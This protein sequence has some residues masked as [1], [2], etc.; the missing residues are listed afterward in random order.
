MAPILLFVAGVLAGL[1]AGFVLSRRVFR[2]RRDDGEAERKGP[3]E[4]RL[5]AGQGLEPFANDLQAQQ[6]KSQSLQE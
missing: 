4:R 3:E 1:I 5:K 2:R 6:L